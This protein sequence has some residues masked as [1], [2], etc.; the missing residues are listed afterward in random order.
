MTNVFVQFGMQRSPFHESAPLLWPRIGP[1]FDSLDRKILDRVQIG[2]PGE[3]DH[4]RSDNTPPD[5]RRA[6]VR[7]RCSAR[8][9]A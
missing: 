2:H 4:A 8:P 9:S 5:L 7:C 1:G 3:R 6:T